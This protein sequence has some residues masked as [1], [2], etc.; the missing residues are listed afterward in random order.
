MTNK[1][2]LEIERS[3]LSESINGLLSLESDALTEEQRGELETKTKRAQLAEVE[4]RAAVVAD[5]GPEITESRGEGTRV[6]GAD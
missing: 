5:P 1:Q 6:Q 4:Y 2:R 3:E